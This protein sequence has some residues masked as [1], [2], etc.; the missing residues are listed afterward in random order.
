MILYNDSPLDYFLEKI[1][2]TPEDLQD[3]HS[4]GAIIFN[5]K[6]EIL[7]MDHVKF[8]FWTIPVGKAKP[9]ETPEDGLLTEIKEELN[10]TPTR[11]EEI[12]KFIK[13]YLW[14]GKKIHTINHLFL[15]ESYKG[16]I[17]NKEPNKHRSLEY[18]TLKEIKK[19]NK[20]SD[21]TKLMIKVLDKSS[22][23]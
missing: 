16:K 6:K 23:K 13:T 1:Q 20:I 2:Y 3:F 9:G 17:K 22:K 8:N 18:M 12:G 10:I 5:D 21:M 15:V 19:L 4:I 7:M 11:Y 14:H